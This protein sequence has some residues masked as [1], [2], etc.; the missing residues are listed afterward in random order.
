M[1]ETTEE[2]ILKYMFC[3]FSIQIRVTN[4]LAWCPQ[5]FLN[6]GVILLKHNR[7]SCFTSC[8]F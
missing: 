1:I 3:Q 8:R 4:M 7:T 5:V 2:K 6:R